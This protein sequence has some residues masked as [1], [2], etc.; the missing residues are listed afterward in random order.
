[1]HAKIQIAHQKN[2][3]SVEDERKKPEKNHSH[4]NS[5]TLSATERMN[6]QETAEK[7]CVKINISRTRN[8]NR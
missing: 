2:N 7:V 6:D 3:N 8:G 1:M 4:T 5:E